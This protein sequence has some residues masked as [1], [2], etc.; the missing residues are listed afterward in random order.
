M[1]VDFILLIWCRGWISHRV[2][3]GGRA[4]GGYGS[5]LQVIKKIPFCAASREFL[6]HMVGS[7]IGICRPIGMI[8]P[9]LVRNATSVL[10]SFEIEFFLG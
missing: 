1:A 9:A 3:S 7:C 10:F 8:L 5:D 2:H 6:D 4:C